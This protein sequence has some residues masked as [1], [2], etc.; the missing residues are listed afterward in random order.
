MFVHDLQVGSRPET[1][2][3]SKLF[4]LSKASVRK[5]KRDATSNSDPNDL[6]FLHVIGTSKTNVRTESKVI[7]KIVERFVWNFEL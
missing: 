5:R 4:S 6:K 2:L 3:Y 1:V 7:L